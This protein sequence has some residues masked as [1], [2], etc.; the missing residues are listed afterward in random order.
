[1]T[2]AIKLDSLTRVPCVVFTPSVARPD[3][4]LAKVTPEGQNDERGA[5]NTE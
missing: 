4:N 3:V 1:M 2:S 5:G